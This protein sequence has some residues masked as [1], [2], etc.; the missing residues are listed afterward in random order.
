MA[1]P[2]QNMIKNCIHCDKEFAKKYTSSKTEWENAKFCSQNC[3]NGYRQGK[4]SPSP[5]TTFKKGHAVRHSNH[6][7]GES[8]N[9]W[10][11]GKISI[12]CQM[13]G[14]VFKVDPYQKD[15][16]NCS[17]KCL[18][19]YKKTPEFRIKLSETEKRSFKNRVGKLKVISKSLDKFIRNSIY[20]K[21]WRETIYTRD[22]FTCQI[23]RQKGGKLQA[24]HIK[25]FAV[26]ILQNNIKTFEEA[27]SCIEL[28]DIKNGRTLCYKCH[29]ATDTYGKRIIK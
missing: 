18:N 5:T 6:Q 20:Y 17:V 2:S 22:D 21:L 16:K 26:I 3:H 12:T 13:C 24:D 29:L 1:Q 11:G 27:V 19:E 23:C 7:K 4:P 8:N 14:L 10:K 9:M 25:Q 15:R 28:W